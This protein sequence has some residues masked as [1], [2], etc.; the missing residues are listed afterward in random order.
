MDAESN[1]V[2]AHRCLSKAREHVAATEGTEAQLQ[3]IDMLIAKNGLLDLPAPAEGEGNGGCGGHH[4]DG[5][6][7]GCSHEHNEIDHEEL[8]RAAVARTAAAAAAAPAEADGS[9]GSTSGG[10]GGGGGASVWDAELETKLVLLIADHGD[11]PDAWAEKAATLIALRPDHP[12]AKAEITAATVEARW[13]TLVSESKSADTSVALPFASLLY[14]QCC[15]FN[16]H[17]GI[18]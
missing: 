4:G 14:H 1:K 10:S 3:F 5:D 15:A 13:T 8:A 9:G 18:E 17:N 6:G 2:E 7:E 16:C 12:A 11:A